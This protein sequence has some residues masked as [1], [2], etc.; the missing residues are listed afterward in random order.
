MAVERDKKVD[1]V[2]PIR[3]IRPSAKFD[4][5]A[6]WEPSRQR[7]KKTAAC[8]GVGLHNGRHSLSFLPKFCRL[9]WTYCDWVTSIHE[10]AISQQVWDWT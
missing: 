8:S 9:Q 4:V 6:H 2:P 7:R 1:A 5:A 10:K 3:V